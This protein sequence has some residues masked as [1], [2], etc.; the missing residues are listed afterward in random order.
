[1]NKK[2]NTIEHLFGSSTRVK[3]LR[4]FLHHPEDS[5]YVRELSRRLGVQIHAVRRELDALE[6][7]GLLISRRETPTEAKQ[8][9]G[10]PPK[11]G[12]RAPLAERKYYQTNQEHLLYPE[13]RALITKADLLVEEQILQRIKDLGDVQYVGLMGRFL[14][15]R[16]LPT[17][18]LVVG[19]LP[20]KPLTALIAELEAE[21][22]H[23]I[24]YTVLTPREFKYRKDVTD[25][26]LFSL[27]EAKKIVLVDKT[28]GLA[29]L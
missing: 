7:V 14:G 26:F 4:L 29:Q 17:D 25:R 21:V 20:K 12:R 22:G 27:L 2:N 13:L 24:D 16:T 10:D 15:D 6:K 3:L 28:G 19:L 5:F 11:K 23:T 18:M 8:Q 9:P 1:M